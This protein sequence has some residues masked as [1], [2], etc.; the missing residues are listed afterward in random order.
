MRPTHAPADGQLAYWLARA[1]PALVGFVRESLERGPTAASR[2]MFGL[3]CQ[4]GVSA[5]PG[6]G[7]GSP[8][9]AWREKKWLAVIPSQPSSHLQ[10]RR[11]TFS[12][13]P[14]RCFA[15]RPW[16]ATTARSWAV[17]QRQVGSYTLLTTSYCADDILE[18]ILTHLDI[19]SIVDFSTVS[20]DARL[21][22]ATNHSVWRAA[23]RRAVKGEQHRRDRLLTCTAWSTGRCHA[24]S[25]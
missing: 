13:F 9:K 25:L 5:S 24:V 20:S 22:L 17:P 4:S 18:T 12:A 10:L 1:L 14:V 11:T 2:Q 16:G 8:V 15:G 7:V 23:M 3:G 19:Q 6:C 21:W